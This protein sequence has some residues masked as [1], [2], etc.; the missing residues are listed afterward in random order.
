MLFLFILIVA[1]ILQLFLPWWIIVPVAF[2]LSLWRSTAG[3]N[4]FKS[5]FWA[6]FLLWIGT[7]LYYT[8]PNQN[9]LANRVAQL[10]MLP[11]TSISWIVI[12]LVTA[13]IGGLVAGLAALAGYFCKAAFF[14]KSLNPEHKA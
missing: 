3:K 6:I 4:A 7:A 10:F 1:F 8:I 12:L 11:E 9:L 13:L 14:T 5:G 2:A